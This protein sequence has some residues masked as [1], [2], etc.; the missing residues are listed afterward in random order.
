MERRASVELFELL[1]VAQLPYKPD[2]NDGVLNRYVNANEDFVL[3]VLVF[4]RLLVRQRRRVD[5]AP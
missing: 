3:V 1:R 5:P 2:L 4:M